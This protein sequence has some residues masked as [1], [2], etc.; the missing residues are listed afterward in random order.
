[1][2]GYPAFSGSAACGRIYLA[3]RVVEVLGH[4]G[5]VA[6]VTQFHVEGSLIAFYDHCQKN[7]RFHKWV[8]RRE[9]KRVAG[10]TRHFR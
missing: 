10:G 9:L 7:M 4:G 5:E 6:Q 8:V 2:D 3:F 1:M